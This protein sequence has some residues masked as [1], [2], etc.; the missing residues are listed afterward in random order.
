[1]SARSFQNAV[2]GWLNLNKPKGMT[3]TAALSRVRG[4]FQAKKAGHA[5]TL[6][7]LASGV[8][9]IAFGEATKT[10][11]KMVD[12]TKAYSFTVK[13]GERTATDDSE[14]EI[15]ESSCR[16]PKQEEIEAE[17]EGFIGR[18]KQVPPAYSAIKID[19]KRSYDLARAGNAVDLAAREVS[20]LDLQLTGMTGTQ[21][22]DFE[23]ECGKGVYVRALARDIAEKLGT[24]GHVTALSRTRVGPFELAASIALENLEEIR[25]KGELNAYLKPVSTSLDDIPALAVNGSQVFRLRMGQA[26]SLTRYQANQVSNCGAAYASMGS[27]VVATGEIKKGQFHPKRVFNLPMKGITDVDYA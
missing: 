24:F 5:G 16:R 7:P 13:W 8:L 18:I 23:V 20:V 12:R 27:Q 17:L 25:H 15:V 21:S 6:D 22:S 14:G 3:S 2:H 4:L 9:P 10:V 11:A 19:G 1:M 26:I